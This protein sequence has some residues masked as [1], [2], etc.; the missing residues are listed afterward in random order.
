REVA[1]ADE[2]AR[3]TAAAQKA[4]RSRETQLIEALT[5][6][7]KQLREARELWREQRAEAEQ[8]RREVDRL[9]RECGQAYA[10]LHEAFRTRVNPTL[11]A[12]WL[13][14]LYPSVED[15][16]RLRQ[17]ANGLPAARQSLREAEESLQKWGERKA[18][19]ATVRQNLARVAAELPPNR[20]TLRE[21]YL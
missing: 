15:V 13:D 16:D 17:Q 10:D 21:D 19:E 11:P 9:Q 7:D 4:A 1:T 5:A 3:Q 8:A 12:N 6:V 18:Q 20:Q 2:Q 14:T